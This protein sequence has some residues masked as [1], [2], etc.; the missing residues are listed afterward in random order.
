MRI[1]K[2]FITALVLFAITITGFRWYVSE[3]ITSDTND[4]DY[5][6]S[7]KKY[8][9]TSALSNNLHKNTALVLGSSELSRLYDSKFHPKQM[10]NAKDKSFMLIGEG[11]F[12]SL[13]HAIRLGAVAP[14]MENKKVNLIL[15]PQWFT[16]DGADAMSFTSRFSEDNFIDFLKNSNIKKSTK[17]KI[18]KRTNELLTPS[19]KVKERVMKYEKV[20]TSNKASI[21]D[22]AYT[23][24]FASFI[25]LK[26]DVAFMSDYQSSDVY[27]RMAKPVPKFT[28][29]DETRLLEEADIEG[30]QRV[31][32][33]FNMD[34][35]NYN[36]RYKKRVE[37]KKDSQLNE[38]YSI[39]PEYD[40]LQ[41][42]LDVCKQ[43]KISVNLIMIP[44][45]GA[46]YDHV[47]FSKEKRE[48]YYQNIRTVARVNKVTLSDLSNHEYSDYFFM[49]ATHCGWK[50]WVYVI[51]DILK[52]EKS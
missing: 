16:K 19:P 34:N 4:I 28:G 32:N 8:L 9:S 44:V 24:I 47:G 21:L 37:K 13:N 2:A 31:S 12:Q 25:S 42:F 52:F 41:L 15:S 29:I 5:Y 50:G 38:S 18:I 33:P 49:D 51:E 35:D 10:V 23:G 27:H 40:D 3:A 43:N 26:T 14:S 45:N 6:L 1:I 11:Y 30:Q 7:R 39:S 46:W 48:E 20:Y 22:S 36:A 17:K